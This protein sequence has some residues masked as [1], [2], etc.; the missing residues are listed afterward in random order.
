VFGVPARGY[1]TEFS[2]GLKTIGVTLSSLKE[3]GGTVDI[4]PGKARKLLDM[5]S[6]SDLPEDKKIEGGGGEHPRRTR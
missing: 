3:N 6:R 5:L 2:S 1:D 4:V